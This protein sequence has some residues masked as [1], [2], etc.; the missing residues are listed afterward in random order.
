MRLYFLV[1]GRRT[2]KKLYKA[3]LG[4]CFPQLREVAKAADLAE[5]SFFILAGLGYPSYLQRI[6]G[7]LEDSARQGVDHLFICIDSEERSYSEKR[8]EVLSI[9]ASAN[10]VL[11]HQGLQYRGQVH[12]I[13]ADC[14]IE[15]WLLGHRRLV[16]RQPADAKL[17]E[18][19]RF[20]DV[21]QNDPERM[22]CPSGHPLERARF[23]HEYLRQVF[24]HHGQSYTKERPGIAVEANYLAALRDRCLDP[25][26]AP[27]HLAS[28]RLLWDTWSALG[29]RYDVEA[30]LSAS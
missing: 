26:H 17:A 15:S 14:C 8:E 4:Y 30:G 1:E 20:Y 29:G 27:A 16:P 11:Q 21:S 5:D 18:L 2:E 3:W 23:H 12:V 22:G 24:W 13:V 25:A 6:P 7:S 19:K 9:L 10:A 28:F